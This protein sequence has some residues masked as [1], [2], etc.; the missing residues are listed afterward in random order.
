VTS[1]LCG[2]WNHEGA[3]RWPHNTRVTAV[4]GAVVRTRTVVVAPSR[5]HDEILARVKSAVASGLV[6]P[7]RDVTSAAWRLVDAVAGPLA[8]DERDLAA[9]L[10]DMSPD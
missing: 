4:D 2:S 9:R 6:V 10:G 1:E 8:L 3:C 7:A 5:D